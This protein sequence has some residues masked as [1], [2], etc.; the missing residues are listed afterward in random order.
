[1]AGRKHQTTRLPVSRLPGGTG[2]AQQVRS[3]AGGEGPL[4]GSACLS[5]GI[6]EGTLVPQA[7]IKTL[8]RR[9]TYNID[10]RSRMRT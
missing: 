3:R 6:A 5:R 7:R 10:S 4:R 1:M 8:S 2:R 9:K